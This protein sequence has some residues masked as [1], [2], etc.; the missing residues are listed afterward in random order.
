VTRDRGFQAG[1][2]ARLVEACF[3]P[4]D[5]SQ[6]IVSGHTF[7]TITF[8][9]SAFVPHSP[10]SPITTGTGRLQDL[11]ETFLTVFH[12][13]DAQL[14][15][16]LPATMMDVFHV[17]TMQQ[18]NIDSCNPGNDTSKAIFDDLLLWRTV[19]VRIMNYQYIEGRSENKVVFGAMP[20]NDR[21]FLMRIMGSVAGRCFC[22]VEVG[23]EKR[24]GLVPERALVGD[25]LA[26]VSG[27]PVP[28]VLREAEN[29]VSGTRQT[30]RLVGDA[31]IT[32]V[33]MGELAQE[34][35]K[36]MKEIVL[37]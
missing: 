13:L 23:T 32:G 30:Y 27:A 17:V 18:R 2:E 20:E 16:D 12:E 15:Q 31:Y 24:V 37:V 25:S 19:M 28:F 8:K 5:K 4:H 35:K 34:L 6:L 1:G 21:D 3:P 9:T 11:F 29:I 26:I 10:N 7:S 33:M 14:T 22:I 36:V